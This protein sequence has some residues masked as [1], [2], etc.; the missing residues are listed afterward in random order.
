[1]RTYPNP[2]NPS[3]TIEFTLGAHAPLTAM[4]YD[5]TG[6]PVRTL[7]AGTRGAPGSRRLVW[8]G[9]RDDGRPAGSGVYFYRLEAGGDARSGRFVL[10]K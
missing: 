4:I 5:V 7:A 3:V 10:V 6:R 2:F 8:D 9:R 1:V